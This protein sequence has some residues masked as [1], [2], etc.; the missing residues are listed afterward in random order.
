MKA[1]KIGELI[2]RYMMGK[3]TESQ[4]E[5]TPNCPS[6]AKLSD[7]LHNLLPKDEEGKIGH[8]VAECLYCLEQLDQA[9]RMVSAVKFEKTTGPSEEVIQRAKEIGRRPAFERFGI[10][11]QGSPTPICEKCGNSNPSQSRYCSQCGSPLKVLI[12]AGC[13][14]VLTKGSRFC[15][16]CGRSVVALTGEVH[17]DFK[18]TIFGRLLTKL[19]KGKWL[20]GALVSFILSFLLPRFFLQFLALAVILG[21]K[22]IFDTQSTRTLIMIYDAWRKRGREGPEEDL[23]RLRKRTEEKKRL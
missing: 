10:E 4:L 18:R 3:V 14:R 13:S 17:P 2:R 6:E 15:P 19:K 20:I 5:R 1:K 23:K 16:Y 21:G 22:W 7:Y 9:Q 12:C 11:L 8:H